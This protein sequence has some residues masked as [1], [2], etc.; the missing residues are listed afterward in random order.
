MSD[1][2]EIT[3]AYDA[4][5]RRCR[6]SVNGERTFFTWDGNAL[7][8]ERFEDQPAREYVY[9]PDTFEPLAAIDGDGQVY[10]YHNDPNGL[11]REL[12]RPN[13]EIVWSASYDHLGRVAQ[14]AVNEVA[15]PLRLQG[16]YHDPE[17]DL[18]YNR[19]RYFDPRICAFISQDPLGLAAG[20]NLYAYAPNVWGWVDPLGLSCGKSGAND[21]GIFF[22]GDD[23]LQYADRPDATLGR[24]DTSHFFMPLDDSANI[25]SVADAA[26]ESGHAP[27]ITRAY[28]TGSK[29]YGVSFPINGL[30]THVPTAAD[31][32]GFPHFFGGGKTAVRTVDPQGGF[33]LN[34]TR[35]LVT[36]GGGPMPSGSVLFE[37]GSNGSWIPLRKF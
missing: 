20:T 21:R 27:S 14:I 37:M 1:I 35:E 3:M 34:Y 15:Q 6:K 12:T 24:K 7:L 25:K 32:G 29:G 9:Y 23:V 8:S 4:L 33:L 36:P 26:R 2:T 22:F 28:T 13:G 17:L 5:G 10:Y 16:Q 18:C 31:A 19:H 30:K 11:P